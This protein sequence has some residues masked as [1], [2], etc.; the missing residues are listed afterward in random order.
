MSLMLEEKVKAPWKW[1]SKFTEQPLMVVPEVEAP[2]VPAAA[3]EAATEMV[4]NPV[5]FPMAGFTEVESEKSVMDWEM[6]TKISFVPVET[7]P[8]EVKQGT[9]AVTFMRALHDVIREAGSGHV[10]PVRTLANGMAG[11]RYVHEGKGDCLVGRVLIRMGQA[12]EVV[13]QYEGVG[14]PE[15]IRRL[16]GGDPQAVEVMNLASR[17]QFV[18]DSRQPW[19]MAQHVAQ[20]F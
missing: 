12:P 16:Y 17:A 20:M 1:V 15:V 9:L 3:C 10:C 18:N 7:G 2:E 14:A 19:G 13:R 4:V 5:K 8:I 6:F 11:F